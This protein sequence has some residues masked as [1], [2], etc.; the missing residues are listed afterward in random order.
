MLHT[1]T[2]SYG[3]WEIT[4]GDYHLGQ[5]L[6]LVELVSVPWLISIGA[7]ALHW[8]LA[9][10]ATEQ[11]AEPPIGLWKFGRG[12]FEIA[13]LTLQQRGGYGYTRIARLEFV[14]SH[15]VVRVDTN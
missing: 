9:F 12:E 4:S 6:L 2:H 15:I 14:I 1:P 13:N 3:T 8:T 5:V 7:D 10:H 11:P